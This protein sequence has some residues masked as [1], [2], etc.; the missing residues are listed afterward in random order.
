RTSATT[1]LRQAVEA[2]AGEGRL[3]E[4]AVQAGMQILQEAAVAKL[5]A[6]V[7]TAEEIIRTMYSVEMEGEME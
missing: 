7:T 5:R 4:M 1:V 2:G 6:G 3:R